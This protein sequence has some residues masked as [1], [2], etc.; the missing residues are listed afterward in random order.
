MST[1][2]I[3]ELE[4]P[5]P[6]PEVTVVKADGFPAPAHAAEADCFARHHG[7]PGHAQRALESARVCVVGAGGL[8]GWA[9]LA[10]ARSGAKSMTII[11]PDRFERSNASRQL[12][13]GGDVGVHKAFAV[14]RN[15]APHMIAGG[16]MTAIR[17]PFALAAERYAI[18]ADVIL[19]LV[20]NNP[21]RLD[22]VRFATERRI[23]AVFAMLSA[24]SMRLH[25]FLQEPGGACLWCALPDLDPSAA[26][27]CA[28]AS[29]ASCL[30]A[31]SHS[32]FLT[33]RAL[34]GWPP[35]VEPFNWR[36]SDLLGTGPDRVGRIRRRRGCAVCVQ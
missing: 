8:G 30:L 6:G 14:A 19:C 18:G 10:L 26:A 9:A 23:P 3:D 5:A 28:A 15:L 33:H 36:E 20:D 29:M 11:E 4:R 16:A 35:G 17:L 21:C 7:V 1:S 25:A 22:A 31:A 24:D 2:L 34:M 12:M 13:F 27:P 32:V